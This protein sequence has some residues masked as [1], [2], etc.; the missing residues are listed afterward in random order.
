MK[1]I[2]IIFQAY[3]LILLPAY[4]FAQ[5]SLTERIDS[6]ENILSEKEEWQT[7]ADTVKVDILN[8]LCWSY[9]T[10]DPNKALK[11]GAEANEKGILT[12]YRKGVKES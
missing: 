6:L 2:L 7:V 11:Y 3:I 10:I 1:F 9:A 8:E 4:T 12:G 5:K